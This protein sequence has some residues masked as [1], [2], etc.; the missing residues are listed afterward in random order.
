MPGF[1][2]VI[3]TL[4]SKKKK[5]INLSMQQM[6]TRGYSCSDDVIAPCQCLDHLRQ[7]CEMEAQWRTQKL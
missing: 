2:V 3:R 6:E 7:V 4:I 1:V 5:I